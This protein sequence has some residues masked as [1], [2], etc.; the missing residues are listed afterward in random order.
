M[1]LELKNVNGGTG[2]FQLINQSG[3]G[4]FSI[5]FS[6]IPSTP[7]TTTT[8]S[9]TSTTTTAPTT[10]TT[11]TSTTSTTTTAAPTTTTTTTTTTST[12]TTTTTSASNLESGSLYFRGTTTSR[13]A[14]SGSSDTTLQFG[15]GSFTIE[16]WQ[17]LSSS[18]GSFPRVFEQSGGPMVSMEGSSASRTFYFWSG[19]GFSS[20]GNLTSS[21]NNT[22]NHFA[23][24]RS[25]SASG[26][27][28]VYRNGV[29]L[30]SSTTVV[31][32][33]T[34]TNP[35]NIGNRNSGLA[36]E[37]FMGNIT[38]FH[39]LKGVAKYSGSFTPTGP[40]S[41]ISGSTGLLL[42]ASTSA[43]AYTDSS[44]YNRV[45]IATTASWTGSSPF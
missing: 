17:N 14:T 19:A 27:L 2:S 12:T 38:N 22:W 5:L 26:N 18:A 1:S 25:G 44:G 16:W 34:S 36:S 20:F 21:L 4:Q 3:N 40:L 13:I 45:M 41:P 8:T 24:V 9:T 15:T 11:T 35:I 7:S 23:V 33:F 10:T 6:A 42:L 39:W 30:G 37:A 31:T 29:Q 43:S 28:K 32:N